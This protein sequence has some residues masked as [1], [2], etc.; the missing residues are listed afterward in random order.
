L[1][2]DGVRITDLEG[3]TVK[4]AA[5]TINW[6]PVSVEKCGYRHF[7]IKEIHEQPQAVL[8][9][10]RGRFS[11]ETGEVFLE[12]LDSACLKNINR[13]EALACGTSYHASLIGKYMIETI[14][15]VPVQVDIASE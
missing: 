15:R 11:E 14:A 8:D 12:G 5:Q 1:E 9:T 3:K 6:D 2:R 10:L 13:I 7:M 4:R